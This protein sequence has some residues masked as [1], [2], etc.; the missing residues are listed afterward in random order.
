M[1]SET[2]PELVM[3]LNNKLMVQF[4][5]KQIGEDLSNL[6]LLIINYLIIYYLGEEPCEADIENELKKH[7]NL[8]RT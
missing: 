5:R 3:S 8:F 4:I 1:H 2:S 7:E 6:L